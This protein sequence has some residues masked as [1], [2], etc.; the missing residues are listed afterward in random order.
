MIASHFPAIAAAK[1]CRSF[2]SGKYKLSSSSKLKPIILFG[3]LALKM[4]ISASACNCPSSPTFFAEADHSL[5]IFSDQKALSCF[6]LTAS[7]KIVRITV[8]NKTQVSIK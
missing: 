1:T 8:G 7:N 6:D 2:K 3:Q 4:D 5:S